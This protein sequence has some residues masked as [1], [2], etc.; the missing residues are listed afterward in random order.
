MRTTL[1]SVFL[2]VLAAP[3]VHGAV[4]LVPN[5]RELIRSSDAVGIV[6]IQSSQSY[7]VDDSIV[8]D[9]FASVERWMGTARPEMKIV[10]TQR[11]GSIGDVAM[12]VSSEPEFVTGERALLMLSRIGPA[13]FRVTSGE[14]A[15][16]HSSRMLRRA[17][18]SCEARRPGKS[19]V[20]ISPAGHT[21]NRFVESKRSCDTSNASSKERSPSVTISF[22]A[23]ARSSVSHRTTTSP[24]SI[25]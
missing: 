7:W 11:G 6:T 20:G 24:A 3:I 25:T 15:S 9:Y 10:I 2:L 14:L 13:Q 1:V 5:D 12:R 17:V 22:Q 8:T 4:Y 18:S 16:F 19:S 21:S 23:S